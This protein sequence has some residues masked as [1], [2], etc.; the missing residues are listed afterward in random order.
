MVSLPG[1]FRIIIITLKGAFVKPLFYL[2]YYNLKDSASIPGVTNVEEFSHVVGECSKLVSAEFSLPIFVIFRSEFCSN[3]EGFFQSVQQALIFAHAKHCGFFY[4][5]S[6]VE[7]FNIAVFHSFYFLSFL[8]LNYS[9]YLSI[10][11]QP[12]RIFLF[13]FYFYNLLI[14]YPLCL[15]YQNFGGEASAHVD[16]KK[17]PDF[18]GSLFTQAFQGFQ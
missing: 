1:S 17:E 15:V 6:L 3:V 2:F 11:Q 18:S 14:F 13:I 16:N 12:F 10:C 9:T 4:L 5:A 7:E 8:Y